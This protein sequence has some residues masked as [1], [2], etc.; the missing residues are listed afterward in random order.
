MTSTTPGGRLRRFGYRMFYTLP[1]RWR[2]VLVRLGTQ[3]YVVGA[4]V[5]L[6][7]SQAPG[8]G[9]LLL[10][11][12]PPGNGWSLPA[13]LM[14]RG[15]SPVTAA[16]REL[17]EESGV[18]LDVDAFTPAVPCAVLHVRGRW[19]DM[20]YEASVPAESTVLSV[21]GAEVLEA[22]FHRLDALPPLT[23]ATARLLSHYGIGPY[24][25]YPEARV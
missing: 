18:R 9:R 4:V 14:N 8:P 11:R 20:V 23:L 19:I 2:R 21:D 7:D 1:P 5:L 24:A 16:A 17:A 25:D 10:L 22:Q 6:R 3:K 15:E 13:G 12:Q